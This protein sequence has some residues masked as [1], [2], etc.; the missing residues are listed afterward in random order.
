MTY[1]ET[2]KSTTLEMKN[3]LVIQ[4]NVSFFFPGMK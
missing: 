2:V 3:N 4:A 1:I